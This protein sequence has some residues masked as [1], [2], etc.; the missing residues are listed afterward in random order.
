M[1]CDVWVEHVL[2][3]SFFHSNPS[4]Q[5]TWSRIKICIFVYESQFE[6]C[7]VCE[8]RGL[9]VSLKVHAKFIFL[10]LFDTFLWSR[11]AEKYFSFDMH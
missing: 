2:F 7:R 9:S 11:Q 1:W 3:C 6:K 8:F 4:G 5:S 10:L